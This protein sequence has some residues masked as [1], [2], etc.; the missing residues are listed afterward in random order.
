ML[1]QV[2]LVRG[3]IHTICW[4]ECKGKVVKDN[5]GNVWEVLHRY[6]RG[7]PNVEKWD[8]GGIESLMPR[9]KR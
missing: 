2:E 5:D 3:N 9:R 6:N 8:V 7:Y 1:T 4:T